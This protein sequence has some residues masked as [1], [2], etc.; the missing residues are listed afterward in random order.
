MTMDVKTIREGGNNTTQ[1]RLMGAVNYLTTIIKL[2]A[3]G[4]T[5]FRMP[6]SVW[7][8]FITS[9]LVLLA[10]PVLAS[11]LNDLGNTLE[12]AGLYDRAI[13]A[14]REA[15]DILRRTHGARH[16]DLAT[17]LAR[18]EGRP[19]GLMA[20]QPRHLGGTLGPDLTDIGNRRPEAGITDLAVAPQGDFVNL[21]FTATEKLLFRAAYAK[22]YGRPNFNQIIPNAIGSLTHAVTIRRRPHEVWP[23]LAQMGAGS[24]AGWYSYDLLDNGGRPSATRIRPE[25]QALTVGM[26]FPALVL[27]V[28]SC[29]HFYTSG[30]GIPQATTTYSAFGQ[31]TSGK[32]KWADETFV[33]GQQFECF[34]GEVPGDAY[35]AERL[36][37]LGVRFVM[38]PRDAGPVRMALGA[39]LRPV[40]A[41]IDFKD[42]R[43]DRSNEAR[44]RHR[45]TRRGLRIPCAPSPARRRLRSLRT[46]ARGYPSRRARGGSS[47]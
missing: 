43:K 40:V 37:A 39:V 17:T 35:L 45:E 36:E 10:T 2:R 44:H 6:L 32:R 34:I 27:F 20:S 47:A 8:L 41:A 12:A 13:G 3:P 25:L 30:Y 33:S 5:M 9:V 22:T 1:V 29:Y 21:T 7:S 24:R 23:W 38:S 11:T 15:L 18:V 14:H 16:P 19:I 28:L 4:M 46:R 26:V 42:R 31:V